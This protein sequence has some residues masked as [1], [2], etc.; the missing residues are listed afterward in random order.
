MIVQQSGVV[1]DVLFRRH[2]EA[3]VAASDNVEG[4]DA[5]SAPLAIGFVDLVDSTFLTR[6]LEPSAL[7]E[8]MSEFDG[9]SSD[10]AA[11]DGRPGRE[12][13]RRRGDVRRA[14]PSDRGVDRARLV[15]LARTRTRCSPGPGAPLRAGS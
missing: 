14:D 13:H 11:D 5:T 9:P 12:A 8:A 15:P 7:A 2:I 6:T 4:G 1:L 3:V 10:I